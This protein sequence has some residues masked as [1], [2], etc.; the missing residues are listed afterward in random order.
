MQNTE[1]SD[2][3]VEL[4]MAEIITAMIH[5]IEAQRKQ[6]EGLTEIQ[7]NQA[8]ALQRCGERLALLEG[9]LAGPKRGI[10]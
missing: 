1:Q 7:R 10:A 3:T 8:A 6:I 5:E 9:R 2:G 4:P